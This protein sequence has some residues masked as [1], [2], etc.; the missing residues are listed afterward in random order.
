MD[1]AKAIFV[2]A[3]VGGLFIAVP[4]ASGVA[5]TLLGIAASVGIVYLII[6]EWNDDG[7]GDDKE[8]STRGITRDS[9]D[10]P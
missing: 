1:L 3:V 4:I 2:I 6:R 9:D 10:A 5:G 7:S 8:T